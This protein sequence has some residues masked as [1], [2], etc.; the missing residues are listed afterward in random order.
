MAKP[1]ILH[2]HFEA[3]VKPL[4]FIN[5]WSRREGCDMYRVYLKQR[6]ERDLVSRHDK[7]WWQLASH[8]H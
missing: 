1:R 4:N 5:H 2:R 3:G 7:Q 6:I 8:P